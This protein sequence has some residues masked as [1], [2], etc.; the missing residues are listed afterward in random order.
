MSHWTDDPKIHALMT[1]L[2]KVGATGK[3]TRSAYIADQINRLL[4]QVET[5]LG[6]R[7]AAAKEEEQLSAEYERLTLFVK[8]RGKRENEL[9]ASIQEAKRDL[10]SQNPNA[11]TRQLDLDAQKAVQ[12]FEDAQE[13]AVDQIEDLAKSVTMKRT[14]IRRIDDRIEHSRKQVYALLAQAQ[15]GGQSAA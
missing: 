10:L 11:D 2:G 4:V 13:K 5:R 6:E 3:P 8:E 7:R 15:K 1:H 14:T 12:E 9:K